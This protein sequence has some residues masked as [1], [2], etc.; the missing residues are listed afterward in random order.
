MRSN[1][2]Q[3]KQKYGIVADRYTKFTLIVLSFLIVAFGQPAFSSI[4]SLLTACCGY[5]LFWAYLV[6]IPEGKK[7]FWY[8]TAWFTAVQLVQLSWFISHPF[9]YIYPLWML[10]SFLMGLQFGLI[11]FFITRKH[12]TKITSIFA[13]AGLWTLLEWSRLHLLSGFSWNPAGLALSSNLYSLQAASLVGLY[14]LTFWV[15]TTNGLAVRAWL[16]KKSSALALWAVAAALPFAYGLWHLRSVDKSSTYAALLVQTGFPVEET[17]GK[18]PAEL[19]SYVVEEW[20]TILSLTAPFQGKKV[21]LVALPEFVVP[22]GTYTFLYSYP[23]VA[24]AFIHAFGKEALHK[25]PPLEEPLAYRKGDHWFVNNAYW[26]QGLANIF[27][28][29]LVS[30]LEDVEDSPEKGREFFSSA[31]LFIPGTFH[32]TRYDKQILVPMGEY[33]PF[34][35]CKKLAQSYGI[36]ASF[37]PGTGAK[38]L[39]KKIPL[40]LSICYEETFGDLMR[41]NKTAGAEILVNLTSDVWYPDSL[42]PQQ[43]LDHARLR[44]V[45]NGLPLLRA[46]NT[47]VTCALDSYGRMIA[48][49]PTDD[50]WLSEALFVEV[51]KDR[52]STLYSI[53]GDRLILAISLLFLCFLVL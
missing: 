6:K 1:L 42:L 37:T 10:L 41:Q 20:K 53:V 25:L 32:P 40:G 5:A 21:D 17:L 24:N 15:F 23:L 9:Y 49:L 11:S 45:E 3:I 50:Q 34:T 51:P 35:F 22:Y 38:P 19:I 12:L 2:C 13:L 8:G 39:G 31:I 27:N 18:T 43:H 26:A 47:G 16:L 36:G 29:E 44:T 7:R 4:F 48:T 33:I 46:C 52:Y 30:G 28:A 14:G